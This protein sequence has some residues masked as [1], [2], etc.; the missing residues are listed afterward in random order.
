MEMTPEMEALKSK[1]RATWIAGDFGEIAKSIAAGGEEF[2]RRLMVTPEMK[3][4]DVAC[5]TGNLAIPAARK[6]ADVTGVDI[7][8]NLIEQAVAN[9]AAENLE[10]KFEVGDAE[11]MPYADGEFDLVMTMF[12]AMFAP[13]PEVT[14]SELK[15][16]CAP[17][18]RIAMANWSPAGFT[19]QMF[20]LNAKHVPPPPEI[21]SPALWGD[22]ETVKERFSK[23]V[24]GLQLTKRPITF[25][26][27][28]GPADVVQHFITY[29]GPTNKAF[30]S[31]DAEKQE[32]FRNEMVEFWTENNHATDGTTKVTSEYLEVLASRQ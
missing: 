31:L 14:A 18:G 29:F 10:A 25:T 15:R 8:P 12:G 21:P 24:T 11:A 32:A 7:A 28:F 22:E 20:K 4:L 17:G 9:A 23:G 3:V 13:R 26:F 27:P 6:G 30:G 2:V 1:L 5:G 16:V 19:G